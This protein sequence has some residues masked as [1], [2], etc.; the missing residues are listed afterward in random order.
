MLAVEIVSPSNKAQDIDKKTAVYLEE[1][2]AEVR[3]IYPATRSMSVF[4]QDSW[5]RVTAT[6]TCSLLNVTID[7]RVI[8]PAPVS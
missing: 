5:Q 4:R 6:Y 2:A 3:V 1:G 8:V 7:L